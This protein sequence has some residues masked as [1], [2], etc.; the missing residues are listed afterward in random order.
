[1]LSTCSTTALIPYA[2]YFL[3]KQWIWQRTLQC[4]GRVTLQSWGPCLLIINRLVIGNSDIHS[5]NTGSVQVQSTLRAEVQRGTGFHLWSEAAL[6][7]EVR[8]RTMQGRVGEGL[9]CV[10]YLTLATRGVAAGQR[11]MPESMKKRENRKK[12]PQ[13]GGEKETPASSYTLF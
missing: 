1:M 6:S 13:W 8:K 3:F 9:Y 2:L 7:E 10:F 12:V 11:Q 5:T 4:F